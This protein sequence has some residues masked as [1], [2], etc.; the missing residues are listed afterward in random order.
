MAGQQVWRRWLLGSALTLSAE[1]PGV[2]LIGVGSVPGNATDRSG[3]AGSS[4]CQRDDATV[5]IDQAT[6]G[7]FGSGVTYT[8]FGNVFLA[9]PDRGP[10][11]GRTDVPYL[12]RFHF[13]HI[14]VDP[15]SSFPN[16]NTVLVD[17][18][19]LKDERRRPFVGDAY[20]FDTSN[21][22]A[23]RRFD[24]EAVAVGI[25]GTFFVV[26]RIWPLYPRVRS[27]RTSAASDS[28]AREVPARSKRWPPERR[29]STAPAPRSSCI[30]PTT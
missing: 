4:I 13:L 28:R 21:P 3:L 7:G 9:V 29:S 17:T 2:T 6:F 23:A 26:G 18:R 12:D 24:P 25:F 30:P 8:G 14:R 1:N 16:I 15:K 20:A 10:F 11:D 22:R 5:C 27:I 19:F